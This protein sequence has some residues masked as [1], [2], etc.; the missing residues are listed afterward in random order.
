M[1]K[2]EKLPKITTVPDK[3]LEPITGKFIKWYRNPDGKYYIDLKHSDGSITHC[4][5]DKID[6]LT[7]SISKLE[8]KK[9]GVVTAHGLQ[10]LRNK[11]YTWQSIYDAMYR[12]EPLEKFFTGGSER[13]N[14]NKK[15][16][17]KYLYQEVKEFVKERMEGNGFNRIEAFN[18]AAEHFGKDFQSISRHYYYKPKKVT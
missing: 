16:T 3:K 18:D 5:N 4:V 12:A 8:K 11:L 1:K 9:N 2:Q 17:K 7:D 15:R 10:S 6:R 14:K 13:K